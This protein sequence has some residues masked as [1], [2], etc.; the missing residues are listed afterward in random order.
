[1]CTYIHERKEIVMLENRDIKFNGRINAGN[2]Q[3]IGEQFRFNYDSFLIR[4]PKIDSITFNIDAPGDESGRDIKL[5]ISN[6]LRETAGVLYV[7]KPNNKSARRMYPEYP[8]FKADVGAVVYFDG[9]DILDGVYDKSI[10]FTIP[11][12][13][14]DSA[15]S[16]DPK[17]NQVSKECS[18][19]EA[20]SPN[21]RKNW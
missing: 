9:A 18:L 11:A 16:S 20:F 12:F 5:G 6:Q 15:S 10:Y 21:L 1:M 2:F 19:Q 8:I 4:L 17:C 3:F 13:E 7:N 14:L